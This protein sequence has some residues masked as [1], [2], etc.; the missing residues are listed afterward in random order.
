MTI[1][2]ICFTSGNRAFREVL[3]CVN[4]NESAVVKLRVCRYRFGQIAARRNAR[5]SAMVMENL[6]QTASAGFF[7]AE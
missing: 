7:A 6:F 3:I 1:V 5:I 4:L 2:Q